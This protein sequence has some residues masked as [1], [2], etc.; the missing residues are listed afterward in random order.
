MK[1]KLLI[2]SQS[3]FGYLIDYVKY[4]EYLKYDFDITYLCW[5]YGKPKV[6][7]PN[8]NVIYISRRGNII[9]RNIRFIL[10][11]LK[12][13]KQNRFNFI[14]IAYFLGSSV[15]PIHIKNNS[16][17]HLDIRTG[18]VSNNIV[19]RITYNTILRIESKSFS[20]IS[21]ISTGLR[22]SLGIHNQA[23]ILPLGATPILINHQNKSQL[24]LLYVGTLTNRRLEKTIIGIKIFLE[25]QP[26]ADIVYTII[27]EGWNHE[28]ENL[29]K[30]INKLN[31]QK[32]IK[33]NGYIPHK[34]L[35]QYYKEANVGISF[36]P[37]TPYFN[38]QP[39]TKTFEY[40]MAGMPVIATKT[41]AN[42]EIVKDENGILIDDNPQ[43]FANGI[44]QMYRY[45]S[46]FS[47]K[48]IIKSVEGYEWSRIIQTMKNNILK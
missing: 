29:Q 18:N 28:N 35:I 42:K 33:L 10:F 6:I 4:C 16:L 12:F 40:L 1:K 14:F 38:F 2:I 15:I 7:E 44:N 39:A 9:L 46:S 23:F 43:S 48:N 17:I 36:I 27:G 31:L 24:H 3:Q 34:E 45:Y 19:N 25:K 22:Q 47:E 41:F 11:I 5:D 21:I 37:M 13:I 30:I 20:S 26:N 8:I 32:H